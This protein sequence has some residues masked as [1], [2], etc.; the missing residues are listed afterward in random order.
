VTSI[1]SVSFI[2]NLVLIVSLNSD[3]KDDIMFTGRQSMRFDV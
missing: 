1:F 2:C 3:G